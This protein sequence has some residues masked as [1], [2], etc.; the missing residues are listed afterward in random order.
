MP[1]RPSKGL[2]VSIP[3]HLQTVQI[4]P[5]SQDTCSRTRE[6]QEIRLHVVAITL[7]MMVE[8]L[9][10]YCKKKDVV[11]VTRTQDFPHKRNEDNLKSCHW[12]ESVNQFKFVFRFSW[13]VGVSRRTGGKARAVWSLSPW[14]KQV[15]WETPELLRAEKFKQDQEEGKRREL[16][17]YP[18]RLKTPRSCCCCCYLYVCLSICV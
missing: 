3:S 2:S 1:P 14:R 5:I 9:C 4:Q 12:T 13:K 15:A 10:V 6:S 16:F 17:G 8:S 7:A 18:W 11:D